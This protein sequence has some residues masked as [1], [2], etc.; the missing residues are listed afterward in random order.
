MFT[1]V[2]L[3]GFSA[4]TVWEAYKLSIY[5]DIYDCMSIAYLNTI[6]MTYIPIIPVF[7]ALKI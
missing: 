1:F 7:S 3:V 6:D 5:N 2:Y 4:L